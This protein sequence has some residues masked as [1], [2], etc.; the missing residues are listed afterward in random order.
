MPL[1]LA[2]LTMG[3]WDTMGLISWLGGV[4]NTQATVRNSRCLELS[5]RLSGPPVL[6]GWVQAQVGPGYL[7]L[8]PPLIPAGPPG[9]FPYVLPK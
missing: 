2:K 3:N 1:V 9:G 8:A 4:A 7:S 5:P 6:T